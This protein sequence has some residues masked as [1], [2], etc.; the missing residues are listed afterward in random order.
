M[1]KVIIINGPNLNMLGK[2]EQDIYG[3]TT[4]KDIEKE[5]QAEAKKLKLRL[6]FFQSNDEAEIID[7]I[8]NSKNKYNSIIINAAAYTHTS[9]A[10]MDALLAVQLPVV[11]VHLSNIYKREEFRHTSYI[12]K[13]AVGTICGFGTVS[14]KLA[15]QAVSAL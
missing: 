8:H 15:L 9:I 4:L 3:K 7:V 11:E 1:K 13:V 10:I 14:Y 12:S 6:D 2:R 5:C